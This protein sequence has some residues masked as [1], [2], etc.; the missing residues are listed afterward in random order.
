MKFEPQVEDTNE[1]TAAALAVPETLLDQLTEEIVQHAK[2]LQMSHKTHVQQFFS[3][4]HLQDEEGSIDQQIFKSC[5]KYYPAQQSKQS[6]GYAGLTFTQSL[7]E[8]S[9]LFKISQVDNSIFGFFID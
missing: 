3:G 9:L 8:N 2:Q 4:Q 7:K 5:K 6:N 1:I